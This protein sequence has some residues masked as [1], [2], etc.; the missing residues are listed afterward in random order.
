MSR[1]LPVCACEGEGVVVGALSGRAG[2]R[3]SAPRSAA[4]P[5]S[6]SSAGRSAAGRRRRRGR[7]GRRSRRRKSRCAAMPKLWSLRSITLVFAIGCQK[8]GQP[9]PESNSVASSYSALAQATQRNRPGTAGRSCSPLNAGSVSSWR[10]TSYAAHD[11]RC[12]H[13]ASLSTS[14][15]TLRAP[16]SWPASSKISSSTSPGVP[17]GVFAAACRR[18]SSRPPP[19]ASNAPPPSATR[20]K[21]RRSIARVSSMRDMAASVEMPAVA[22][23]PNVNAYACTPGSRNSISNSRSPLPWAWRTSWYSRWPVIVPWPSGSVSMPWSAPGGL[24]SMRTR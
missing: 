7:G 13:C 24:P 21:R 8:L 18:G 16:R 9:V 5:S 19:T 10:I 2:F 14:F 20:R 12:R 15:A 6:C 4:P 3:L 23:Q 11:S 1:R 17:T 22:N